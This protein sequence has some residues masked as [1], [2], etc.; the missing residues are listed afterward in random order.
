MRTT[1]SLFV[2]G[3]I[4]V[5]TPLY[6]ATRTGTIDTLDAPQLTVSGQ[7]YTIRPDTELL[8]QGGHRVAPGELKP[9][10]RVELEVDDEGTL[11]ALKATLV[12]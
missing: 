1:L 10:T 2:L 6:A 7:R 5:A 4:L 12:R 9:G 11:V 8:D 3:L